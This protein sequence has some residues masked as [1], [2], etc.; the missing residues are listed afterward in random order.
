MAGSL[1]MMFSD[2]VGS[3]YENV[4]VLTA[5]GTSASSAATRASPGIWDQLQIGSTSSGSGSLSSWMPGSSSASAADLAGALGSGHATRGAHHGHSVSFIEFNKPFIAADSSSTYTPGDN[6]TLYNAKGAIQQ[7][8]GYW[9]SDGTHSEDEVVSWTGY[10]K[11]RH[12]AN[13]VRIN[14]AYSPGSVRI[15]VSGDGK[16]FKDSVCWRK[17]KRMEVVYE[18]FIPFDRSQKIKAVR[19]DMKNP[20]PWKYFGMNH[21]SMY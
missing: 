17:S 9:A 2:L 18:E 4:S 21:I 16:R 8:S 19:I 20:R 6:A 3:T 15:R 12:N 10:L 5:G 14:W 7:G 13:G 1:G 11:H